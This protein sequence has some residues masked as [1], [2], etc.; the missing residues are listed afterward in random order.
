MIQDWNFP[1][2]PSVRERDVCRIALRRLRLAQRAR[3][4]QL[5]VACECGIT[6]PGNWMHVHKLNC[7]FRKVSSCCPPASLTSNLIY[8][9]RSVLAAVARF[10][11]TPSTLSLP[12]PAAA[13]LRCAAATRAASRSF[14][15]RTWIITSARSATCSGPRGRWR[16]ATRWRCRT[17]CARCAATQCRVGGCARTS[18]TG[19]K[20]GR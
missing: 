12:P 4:R 20:H 7:T 6:V 3:Q 17:S 9:A 15:P 19:A 2:T 5:P 11:S 14:A 10:R 18:K 8:L 16:R 1:P 13:A